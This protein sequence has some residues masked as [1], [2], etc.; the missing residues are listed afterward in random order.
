MSC[1]ETCKLCKIKLTHQDILEWK[2][3]CKRA[4]VQFKQ[5]AC[6][7]CSTHQFVCCEGCNAVW[8]REDAKAAFQNTEWGINCSHCRAII[9]LN[10]QLFYVTSN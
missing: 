9:Q 7:D 1:S 8:Y 5:R 10:K 6:I 3:M 2:H 4:P